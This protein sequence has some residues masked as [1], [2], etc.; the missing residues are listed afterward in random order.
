MPIIFLLGA[1]A[2]V[3][4]GV[5]QRGRT[6]D[7]WA[8]AAQQ[9]GMR[10]DSPGF[11]GYPT[12]T[13]QF[14]EVLVEVSVYSSGGKNNQ[15]FTSFEVRHPPAGPVVVLSK[16][17][18][19]SG[20]FGS[21]TGRK[22]VLVGDPLFDERIV[23]HSHDEDAVREF[24]TPA[25]RAAVQEV[26]SVFAKAEIG[27]DTIRASTHGVMSETAKL[28]STITWLVDIASIL[29][30]VRFNTILGHQQAGNLQ[31]A[32]D[33]LHEF[34]QGRGNTFSST[35]EAEAMVEAGN[36]A[37]AAEAFNEL[38]RGQPDE[39]AARGWYQVAASPEPPPLTELPPP[40]AEDAADPAVA[41]PPPG[42][43][44]TAPSPAPA[45][46]DPTPAP[47][48]APSSQEVVLADIFDTNRMSWEVAEHFEAAH[49]NNAIH[50]SGTVASFDPYER[51][52]DFDGGP[53]VKAIVLVGHIG[54]VG[55]ISNEIHAVV[56]L[57]AGVRL[58][59]GQEIRFNGVLAN[60]DRFSRKI[61]VRYATLA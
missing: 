25:R 19:L 2:A 7:A 46:P 22:D 17:G 16:Q 34:N 21:F 9:L 38:W 48:P 39:P 32:A 5:T 26:M 27:R 33:E 14:G 12:L 31:Q 56:E 58:R 57:E 29:G 15:R 42:S 55:I 61:W 52:R 47:S 51:D 30:D 53:G 41:P 3:V 13:G 8:A 43:G 59:E 50:W 36:H 10:M 6:R 45:E 24:L 44:G 28:V 4:I 37:Q 54:R 11:G 40:R 60:V 20:F 35:L 18:M 49:R 1:I 23:V